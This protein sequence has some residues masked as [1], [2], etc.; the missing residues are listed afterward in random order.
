MNI[1]LVEPNFPYPNKSKNKANQV[2]KNFV[3]IALL[4]FAA[5][6][7]AKRD[8]VKLI[9]GKITRGDIG[10]VPDEIYVTSIFTYW[11]SYV[12]D[13][14]SYYR[15]LYPHALIRL[16]GIYATLHS[17]K[18]KFRFLTKKFKVL[19]YKGINQE[20]EKYSPD[21]SVL[22]PVDYHATHM[23]RGCIRKCNFCGTWKLEPERTNKSKD[24][25]INELTKIGKTKVIFYDNNILAN[26]NIK[27]ILKEFIN[28]RVDGKPVIFESQSGF[29][30]RLLEKNPELAN[31]I[32]KARFQ[33]V[34]IAWDN[35][36]E[37]K[38]SVRKQVDILIKA[39]YAPKDISIFMI[40]NFVIP[41][42]DMLKKI[43]SCRERGVQIT[44]C[45][46]R[47]LDIDYD[48]YNPHMRDGQL[49]GSY[50]I[51]EKTGWTD[52]KIRDFRSKVR[53]HNIW[54]RYAKDK[55]KEY[56]N[57]MEK[58]SAI[59]NTYKFFNLGRPPHMEQ[60]EKSKYLQSKIRLL[61]KIKSICKS[62]NLNEKNLVSYSIDEL[63]KIVN[64]YENQDQIQTLQNQEICLV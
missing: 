35:G 21:Y 54:V 42:E 33:N 20:A 23:M 18:Q 62:N 43:K 17:D 56:D 39:G 4:K 51:H 49:S 6:H 53:K 37:D 2:H 48:N 14:L 15:Q 29:D 16:G 47:P 36:L 25:I 58:W 40:Y 27:E 41:Y 5:L 34:R 61:N 55:G 10:F 63:E 60:I 7:K 32:R 50:Y 31:L 12:W 8:K 19:V 45:R 28:F 59:N 38:Y 3:P 46:Y 64:E 24:E 11:S 9:R 1:L 52:E 57:K 22:P 13:C 30:G 26:P 44:D